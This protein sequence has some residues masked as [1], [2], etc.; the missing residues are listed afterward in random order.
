MSYVYFSCVLSNFLPMHMHSHIG[1]IYMVFL[2]YGVEYVLSILLWYKIV[3]R[4]IHKRV[5]EYQD[6]KVHDHAA[7]LHKRF[8]N[9]LK[10]G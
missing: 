4:S 5:A 2:R 1:H 10:K 7:H 6:D 8:P 9:F 3:C